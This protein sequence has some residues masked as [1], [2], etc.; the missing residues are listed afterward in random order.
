MH[1]LLVATKEQKSYV[2]KVGQKITMQMV[3][4]LCLVL[5]IMYSSVVVHN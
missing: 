5:Y 2:F 4:L 3:V 1:C